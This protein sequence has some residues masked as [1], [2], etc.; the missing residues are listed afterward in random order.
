MQHVRGEEE[1]IQGFDGKARRRET[2]MKIQ[3]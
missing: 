2:T 1:D 3:T